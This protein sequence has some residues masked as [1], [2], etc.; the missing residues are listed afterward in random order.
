MLELIEPMG[1]VLL[2]WLWLFL[3]FSGLGIGVL[4]VIGRSADSGWLW[5]DCFWLG[6]ALSLGLMQVWHFVFPIN[7]ALML[8]FAAASICLLLWRGRSLRRAAGRLA[9]DKPFLLLYALLA[10]WMSNRA[11]GMPI[12]FDTGFRDIQ[13][14]MWIDAYPIVPGLGNL[15]SSLAFNHSVY[16]YDAL[17]DTSIWSGRSYY[18]ATGLLLMVYLG[19]ALGAA[20]QFY[21][22]PSA[23]A[24]R[25]SKIFAALT[26]PYILFQTVRGGGITHYL[27]DTVVDLMGF[28]TLIYLLDFLQEWRPANAEG[29]YLVYRLAIVILTGITIKQSYFVYGAATAALAITVWLRRGGLGEKPR[30][31]ARAAVSICLLALALLL[32]WL[33][34]GVV[35]SGYLAYPHSIGRIDLDWTM[36]EDQIKLRQQ[37][38]A[39]NTRLRGGDPAIVLASWDW[40]GPWLR[41]FAANIFPTLL[42]TILSV[43]GL[44][45]YGVATMKHRA[46]NPAPA[47][48]WRV[49]C[50]M[51]VML[52]FWFFSVPED[53]YIRYIL[54]SFAALSLTMAALSWRSIAWRRRILAVFAV[55]IF[56]LAYVIFV[57]VRHGEYFIPAGSAGGFHAHFLPIYHEFVTDD[58]TALN[59]TLGDEPN[60]CWH[61]PLPCTP[62]PKAGISARVKGELRHGFRYTPIGEGSA[63]DG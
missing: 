56:C 29:N 61:I 13:A 6:W 38:L 40:L 27:T 39:T 20:L 45:L 37:K 62:H 50:P 51:L 14:V 17:L 55:V 2:S 34:R 18:I 33:A 32:P 8:L 19:Y 44:C 54:W 16:L 12:A 48:G 60:Q 25:W 59:R 49:L 42:P 23:G 1:S 30:S 53:K 57:I 15:F 11:L 35:T 46:D 24:L 31:A 5:L 21:R 43:V 41:D 36:P 47:L 10:L 9:G 52:L 4:R 28:L 22:S 7:D 58:G 26:I 3:L 63:A